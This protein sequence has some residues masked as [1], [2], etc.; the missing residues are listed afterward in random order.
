MT[1]RIAQISNWDGDENLDALGVTDDYDRDDLWTEVEVMDLVRQSTW[2]DEVLDD[3]RAVFIGVGEARGAWWATWTDPQYS[4]AEAFR[5][6]AEAE[7]RYEAW[8]TRRDWLDYGPPT[9]TDMDG[10]KTV[11]DGMKSI[12]NDDGD[13]EIVPR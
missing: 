7:T 9:T 3:D 2:R 10:I 12:R 6:R 8:M 5:T 1:E 4:S 13:I 11:P